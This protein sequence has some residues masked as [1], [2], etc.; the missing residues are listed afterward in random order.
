MTF[1]EEKTN[2]R[3]S[4]SLKLVK[5][6]R[7]IFIGC[8]AVQSAAEF[9]KHSFANKEAVIIADH[10][11]F[12]AAG[13][14]LMR[15]LTNDCELKILDPF[16]LNDKEI[17]AEYK[18]VKMIEEFLLTNRATPVA[19]GSGTINDLVKL[20][21]AN[22]GREYMIFP[23]AASVD[24]YT[25][26]GASIK[27]DNYKQTISCPAP[28]ALLADIN[29]ISSAPAELNY[30]GYADLIAKIPAGADWLIADA[31]SIDK[32]DNVAW[33]MVQGKLRKWIESPSGI[34]SR[35]TDSLMDL[36]EGLIMGGLAM[37]HA[38]SSRPASGA[39]HIFSHLFDNN[40][41]KYNDKI[42]LHGIKVGIGS[43]AVE[44]I[45]EKLLKMGSD[46]IDIGKIKKNRPEWKIVEERIR[47]LF[48]DKFLCEQVIE[49][50]YKK[51]V[52]EEELSC[53]WEHVKTIWPE[54][55]EKLKIQLYGSEKMKKALQES[56]AAYVPM[57]IGIDRKM[58][59]ENFMQAL[60]LRERYTVLDFVFEA[61]WWG[62]CVDS[63]LDN[64][65]IDVE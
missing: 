17:H 64:Y 52:K 59:R 27:K 1:Y 38:E 15:N 61:G 47:K 31:L 46:D 48:D 19:V 41:Y 12:K 26:F 57:Q 8:D 29:V 7:N 16:I 50:S 63:L 43:I 39:E 49:Q 14:S 54:L 11:T 58:M 36:M 30:S 20:A 18:Y 4:K 25:S 44:S 56:G 37:Q 23:T 13:S 40:N 10:E 21:S 53:R 28:A 34:K 65:S 33:Q 5:D 51:Y 24:G 35:N 45:Y 2:E 62:K 22:C 6:T 3:I 55:K 9:Y 60:F 32:I 42:P